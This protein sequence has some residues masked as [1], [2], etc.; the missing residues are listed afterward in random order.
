M[1]LDHAQR[2]AVT[3][4]VARADG[5]LFDPHRNTVIVMIGDGTQVVIVDP[6]LDR[7]LRTVEL[8][9]GPDFA[10]ADARGKV[11]VNLESTAQLAKVDIATGH[12]EAV[13]SARTSSSPLVPNDGR[14]DGVPTPVPARSR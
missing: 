14:G 12:V 8:P 9:A 6:V 2:G 1:G 4:E 3:G 11:Y 5:V 13:A 10:A 7:V